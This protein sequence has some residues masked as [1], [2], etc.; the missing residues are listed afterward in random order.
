MIEPPADP[1][2][3]HALTKQ[4]ENLRADGRW[5]EALAASFEAF[6]ADQSNAVAAHNLGVM[7][8]KMGR[9]A[10]AERVI[11]H[12]LE[13]APNAPKIIQSLAHVLLAQGRFKEGWRLNEVRTLIPEL[14][15]G[16]P[17][18]FGFPR[19]R[20][21]PL[22]GKRIAVFPEQ[23]LG[24]QI[25]FARFL[26]RLIDQAGSVTLLARPPLE[27]LF[28]YNF[29][30]ADV[31]AAA[32][33]VEF[34]D[35]DYW[36]TLQ[37]LPGVFGVEIDTIPSGPYLRPAGTWPS[38]G[39]GFTIGLKLAGNPGHANDRQRS[40]PEDCA[41]QLRTHLPGTVIS[42]EPEQ[43]GAADL[44]DTAA[45]INQL[46]LVVSVDTSVAHLAGALGKPCLLLVPGF[47]VDWRWM[48]GRGDSPW[49]PHHTLFRGEIDRGW[50][51]AVD[52]LVAEAVRRAELPAV[53]SAPVVSKAPPAKGSL[54]DMLLRGQALTVEAR[55]SEALDLFRRASRMAP[56][57]P[58][59]FSLLG[60]ALMDIG[61]LKES[62]QSLRRALT[63]VPRHPTFENSLSLNLMGQGRY[64]EAWP[65]HEAR[66]GK[67]PSAIGF[68][69]GVPY[70]RWRGEPLAG[71]HIAVL[72]EQGFG[73]AIQFFRFLPRL[74]A[75]DARISLF[76][77]P[78]LIDLFRTSIDATRDLAGVRLLPAE[79]EVR[80][81]E[82][83]YWT[84]LVDMMGPLGLTIDDLGSVPYLFTDRSWPAF[85]DGFTIGLVTSGNPNHA[86]D[87]RRSLKPGEA[88]RLRD[89]LP[90]TIVSLDPRVS[91][92]RDFADTAALIR[93]L[94]LVVSV[95]TSV[96]HLAGALG[97]PCLL[98]V[99]GL[100]TDWRWMR[101][102][103]DSPWYPHH[104]L[105]RSDLNGGWDDA[106]D[107]LAAEANR[108]AAAR[109]G[110]P[111]LP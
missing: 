24:D 62:E 40:L 2:R 96:G 69:N 23:G 57:N 105:F 10:E 15:H 56:D 104:R 8:S 70:A 65:L 67:N 89:A 81:G 13:L 85:P 94:D 76:V 71:R 47:G 68:P 42:L 52:R 106:I 7:L 44:A 31:V 100:G 1:D 28:R 30:G 50:Q 102:R 21:E 36:I 87:M 86:N 97:C 66:S 27:R 22:P 43:S 77:S 49:Y 101:G 38:L 72:P 58:A 18:D 39:P 103:D 45:I 54:T 79:G 51:P 16:F 109:A 60:V 11:R 34:P 6:R 80:L 82:P 17:T 73:D 41:A 92:A 25:Q 26:P 88:A 111:T 61:R 78:A 33:A 53:S 63:L 95:D 9:L 99:P 64:R 5:Q 55:Y 14:N 20:G 32:G 75:M 83:D 91:G 108:L 74:K 98:L 59:P 3:S 93:N 110:A 35:P 46:D 19:W 48:A 107:A 29:P 90:G 84:T 37:D 4:A 12:A